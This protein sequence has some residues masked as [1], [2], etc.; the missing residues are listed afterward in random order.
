MNN[1]MIMDIRGSNDVEV[2][3]RKNC[4]K[5][6]TKLIVIVQKYYKFQKGFDYT[7]MY[8]VQWQRLK[9]VF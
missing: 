3:V 4:L 5:L 1:V 7:Y 2:S 6:L 8:I 9:S